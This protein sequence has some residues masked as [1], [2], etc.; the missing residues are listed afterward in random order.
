MR[1]RDAARARAKE[2]KRR[3]DAGRKKQRGDEPLKSDEE[4]REGTEREEGRGTSGRGAEGERMIGDVSTRLVGEGVE[5]C[6]RRINRGSKDSQDLLSHG[7]DLD[8]LDTW[9]EQLEDEISIE[10]YFLRS[11][12]HEDNVH[13]V[14]TGRLLLTYDV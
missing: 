2:R 14:K 3:G 10:L 11:S 7:L 8:A 1:D 9:L 6:R 5:G 4:S 12:I 13:S